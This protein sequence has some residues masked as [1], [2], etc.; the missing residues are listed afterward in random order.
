[1]RIEIEQ[2]K[3]EKAETPLAKI[4]K[5]PLQPS[6]VTIHWMPKGAK[7]L[8]VGPDP[9]GLICVW[10]MVS[11]DEPAE[12]RAIILAATGESVPVAAAKDYIG[13]FITDDLVHHAFFP[14]TLDKAV[15]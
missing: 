8:H 5:Y 15:S 11:P 14:P 1:M 6:S 3:A 4:W 13:T 7:A 9:N 10:C 12:K 2:G